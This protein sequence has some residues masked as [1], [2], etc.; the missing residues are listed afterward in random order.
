MIIQLSG[1]IDHAWL[2]VERGQMELNQ[3]QCLKSLQKGS[4]FFLEDKA[5]V[6]K[7]VIE[8]LECKKVICNSEK[9]KQNCF[10]KNY[11]NNQ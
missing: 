9:M 1:G 3:N 7:K 10:R 2:R 6:V 8:R 5:K 4:W 11:P